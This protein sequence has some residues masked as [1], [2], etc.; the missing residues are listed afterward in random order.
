MSSTTTQSRTTLSTTGING[1]LC[2]L[3]SDHSSITPYTHASVNY[4][5]DAEPIPEEVKAKLS[6]HDLR[7]T[8]RSE[9]SPNV[10]PTVVRI[11]NIRGLEQSYTLGEHGF[12]ICHL[13]SKMNQQ[14]WSD[15]SK[16]RAIYFPEVSETL[17]RVTG[18]KFVF[19]YEHH[20]RRKSLLEA[21]AL[22]SDGLVDID[23]PVRRVH[24]DES[25]ASA[26]REFAYYLDPQES[27]FNAGLHK[28]G[29][30]F[31][32]Y[33]I[34]LPLKTIHRDPLCVCDART[35]KHRD[36]RSGRVTVPNVGEIENFAILPPGEGEE[37]RHE[38]CFLKG[39]RQDEALVFKI[40]DSRDVVEG[41]EEKGLEREETGWGIKKFGCAHTSFVDPGTES[42]SARESIEVRSFCVF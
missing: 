33:N 12:E 27:D 38:W 10:D 41:T 29:R 1:S 15:E 37:G 21:L 5:K 42:E 35:L 18:A 36:L 7:V 3:P 8:R 4:W 20:V 30:A 14:D 24:I 9:N 31:G 11:K 22:P 39:Q 40:F 28:E 13:S 17:K 23:G 19:S 26:R 32:I 2:L 25:P 6:D 34:W 16:R